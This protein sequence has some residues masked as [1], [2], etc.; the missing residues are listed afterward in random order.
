[1]TTHVELR[2]VRCTDGSID[3]ESCEFDDQG[4]IIAHLPWEECWFSAF[5]GGPRGELSP[6]LKEQLINAFLAGAN[7]AYTAGWMAET[8]VMTQQE[9][10]CTTLALSSPKPDSPSS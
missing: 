6:W 9:T 10:R 1:M 3:V 8:T 4:R 5:L 2:I 7:N